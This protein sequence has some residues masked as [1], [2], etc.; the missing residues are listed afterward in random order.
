[1]AKKRDNLSER[2]KLPEKYRRDGSWWMRDVPERIKIQQR[3]GRENRKQALE[4]LQRPPEPGMGLDGYPLQ[5]GK[6]WNG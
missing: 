6:P 2:V 3:S 5:E 4:E 1:M